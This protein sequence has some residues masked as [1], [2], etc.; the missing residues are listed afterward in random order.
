[1]AD[2]REILP[3][4]YWSPED[5]KGLGIEINPALV[6]AAAS[7]FWED[8]RTNLTD[9][10]KTYIRFD[11]NELWPRVE[12][13][14]YENEYAGRDLDW[15]AGALIGVIRDFT[16]VKDIHSQP[17]SVY[18]GAPRQTS[19]ITVRR[20]IVGTLLGIVPGTEI[21][22]ARTALYAIK[23]WDIFFSQINNVEVFIFGSGPVGKQCIL[24]LNH[25]AGNKIARLVVC[26]RTPESG[27]QLAH[28]LQQNNQMKFKLET[29]TKTDRLSMAQFV[30]TVTSKGSPLVTKDQLAPGAVTLS[31]GTD[32][33][34][35]DYIKDVLTTGIVACDEI[36]NVSER[37]AQALALWFSRQGITLKREAAKYG[38]TELAD[39]QSITK[40]DNTP[41][42][43]ACSGL[44]ALDT[45]VAAHLLKV[46][47]SKMGK[48]I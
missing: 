46:I 47:A 40:D 16:A 12:Y 25:Y 17:L 42:H 9:S 24:F 18:Y 7:T 19:I 37:N 22:N 23:V 30:I 10:K 32:E 20:R 1:M 4:Q 27:L 29:T 34:P 48:T 26:S 35:A 31:L 21:S 45:T 41:V 13:A 33:M 6:L 15:R 2:T 38:V 3:F 39:L 11:Q 43:V 5:L 8:H 28:E 44:A 14:D 36:K